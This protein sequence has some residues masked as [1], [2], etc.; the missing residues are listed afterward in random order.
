[1][2]AVSFPAATLSSFF[3]VL[4]HYMHLLIFII[5]FLFKLK[6]ANSSIFSAV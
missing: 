6:F 2:E 5:F 4:A 3:F 1:M